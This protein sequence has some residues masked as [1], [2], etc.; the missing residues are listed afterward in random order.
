MVDRLLDALDDMDR[1]T[2]TMDNLPVDALREAVTLVDRKFWKQL[3]T[4][5]LERIDPVGTPFDPT[6]H[7]AVAVVPPPSPDQDHLV[8]A[9]FQTGYRFKGA[10][11]RPARVQVYSEQGQA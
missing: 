7:E 6:L 11:V 4:A 8:A 9:T 3:E 10:L 2:A 5:G 1:L